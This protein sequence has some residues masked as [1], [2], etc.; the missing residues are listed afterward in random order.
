MNEALET[1]FA[2]LSRSEIEQLIRLLDKIAPSKA[3]P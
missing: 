2:G 1:A 3:K